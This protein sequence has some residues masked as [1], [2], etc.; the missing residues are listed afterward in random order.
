L[1]AATKSGVDEAQPMKTM[2]M[3]EPTADFSTAAADA[4]PSVEMTDGD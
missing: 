2:Q 3:Q 4:P 1:G